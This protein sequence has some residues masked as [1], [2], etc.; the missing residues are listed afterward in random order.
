MTDLL[1]QTDSYLKTFHALVTSVD[2]ENRGF[3]PGP[4]RFLSGRWGSASGQRTYKIRR[5]GISCPPGKE[6]RR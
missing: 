4:Q 5:A 1:Y 3:K 6:N 2:A